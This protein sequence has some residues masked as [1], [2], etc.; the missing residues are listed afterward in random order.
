MAKRVFLI[1]LDSFGVGGA[2]D[3]AKFGAKAYTTSLIYLEQNTLRIYFTKKDDKFNPNN[4]DGNKGEYYYKDIK[5]IAPYCLDQYQT[6]R[7]GGVKFYYSAFDYAKAVV[8]SGMNDNQKNLA[9]SLYLFNQA[10]KAY[11]TT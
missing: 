5:G 11:F 10:A 1:V 3:A 4:Y 9:K 8:N 7:I 6:L 2:P